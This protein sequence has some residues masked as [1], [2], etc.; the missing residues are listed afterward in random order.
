MS[1]QGTIISSEILESMNLGIL[2]SG[3]RLD[4]HII[5]AEFKHPQKQFPKLRQLLPNLYAKSGLSDAKN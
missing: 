5:F 1:L 2:S 4:L 3:E